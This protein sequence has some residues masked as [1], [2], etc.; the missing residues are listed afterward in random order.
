MLSTD[1]ISHYKL[2]NWEM[3]KN[4]FEIFTFIKDIHIANKLQFKEQLLNTVSNISFLVLPIAGG[5]WHR[6]SLAV[7]KQSKGFSTLSSTW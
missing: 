2:G 1:Y 4:H 5:P 6:Q 7:L 3:K